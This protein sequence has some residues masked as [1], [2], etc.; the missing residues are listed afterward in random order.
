MTTNWRSYS[1]STRA[2]LA[3]LSQGFCYFPGC[4]TPILVFVEGKPEV[5]VE[6]A[7]IRAAEENGPRFV[8]NM[9]VPAR[10]SFSNLVLLC[11]PHHKTVDRNEKAY[12]ISTLESWKATREAGGQE[13]LKGL[14][15]LTEG[16]LDEMLTTAFSLVKEEVAEALSRFERVDEESAQLIRQLLSGLNDHT[17]QYRLDADIAETMT[18]V[19]RQLGPL[20][21]NAARLLS[22]ANDLRNLEDNSARLMNA[23]SYLGGMQETAYRLAQAASAV[24][25]L[26]ELAARLEAVARRIE[27]M[28]DMM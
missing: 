12:S 20:E 17:A 11:V 16:R 25:S 26:D 6:I 10:N 24:R 7:H 3:A 1:V 28:R 27:R 5:N 19:A 22:A 18:H 15:D 4:R 13:A 9:S 23:A 14:K 8:A 21:D 2:A